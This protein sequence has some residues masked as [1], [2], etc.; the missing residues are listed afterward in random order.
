M[1]IVVFPNAAC[2]TKSEKEFT[3][4]KESTYNDIKMFRDSS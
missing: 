2:T 3:V 1:G 4:N